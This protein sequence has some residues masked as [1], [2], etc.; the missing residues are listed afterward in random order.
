MVLCKPMRIGGIS[1]PAA[2]T[3]TRADELMTVRRCLCR[4]LCTAIQRVSPLRRGY[5]GRVLKAPG[6]GLRAGVVPV[7]RRH[8]GSSH[9]LC[10]RV[11]F[12][13]SEAILF[14]GESRARRLL[15]PTSLSSRPAW[16]QRSSP[17][18]PLAAAPPSRFPA[19]RRSRA[20]EPVPS[21][22]GR[23]PAQQ[24]SQGQCP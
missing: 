16:P 18:S 17:T 15:P 6:Q 19:Q 12:P 21:C 2:R 7:L 14:R 9:R 10:Q 20:S 11:P 23:S 24:R 22:R 1:T 3:T 8:E 13:C 5:A 4:S